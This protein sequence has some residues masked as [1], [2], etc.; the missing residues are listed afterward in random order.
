MT[1]RADELTRMPLPAA[2]ALLR[3]DI[4]NTREAL[5]KHLCLVLKRTVDERDRARCVHMVHFLMD[6]LAESEMDLDAA[7]RTLA[8]ML[9]G[10]LEGNA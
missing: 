2:I 7:E 8:E 6:D 4:R 1:A 3:E 5:S 10:V 9:A